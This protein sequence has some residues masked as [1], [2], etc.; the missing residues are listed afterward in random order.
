[1]LKISI[2]AL[3]KT[4][5]LEFVVPQDYPFHG[6][7]SAV[8]AAVR[9]ALPL[10]P[11][12]PWRRGKHWQY[13]NKRRSED[14]FKQQMREHV[15]IPPISIVP[16]FM[17]RRL[18]TTNLSYHCPHHPRRCRLYCKGWELI[19]QLVTS[20]GGDNSFGGPTSTLSRPVTVRLRLI[21]YDNSDGAR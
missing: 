12:F 1:M 15:L 8:S 5:D 16:C 13:G 21:S 6:D 11:S 17:A 2:W 10:S 18:L 7:E 4:I 9:L 19:A 3:K 20:T 14:T